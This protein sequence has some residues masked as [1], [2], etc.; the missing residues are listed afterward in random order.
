MF[1]EKKL[2]PEHI[3]NLHAN[4]QDIELKKVPLTGDFSLDVDGLLMAIN[5]DTRMVYIANPNNPAGTYIKKDEYNYLLE[6]IPNSVLLVKDETY[7][8]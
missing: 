7:F 5:S 3:M 2:I 6:N 8:K 1:S 4:V